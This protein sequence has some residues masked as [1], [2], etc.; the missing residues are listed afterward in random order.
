MSKY[1]RKQIEK[2]I[3]ECIENVDIGCELYNHKM[4]KAS[5]STYK[6]DGEQWYTEII[7]QMLLEDQELFKK[8]NASLER[9][10]SLLT[11]KEGLGYY[12]EDHAIVVGADILVP[13]SPRE[14]EWLAKRLIGRDF[15]SIGKLF[16]YQ[17]PLKRDDTNKVKAGKIDLVSWKTDVLYIVELKRASSVET[18]LRCV[19]EAYTYAKSIYGRKFIE[20]LRVRG[21]YKAE[22]MRIVPCVMVF[23]G[24][25]PGEE[26][27]Q[28]VKGNRPWIEKL[29][30][31]LG[32][33]FC[34]LEDKVFEVDKTDC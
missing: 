21:E 16:D 24:S 3:R 7:S 30:K 5:G 22:N 19:L 12:C 29:V 31:Q 34:I 26:Y 20:D 1:S 2:E 15:R 18:L 10:K 6:K 11:F 8:W 23:N 33:E 13:E 9:H 28:M 32:V 17:I 25:K 4:V 14:E 27:C